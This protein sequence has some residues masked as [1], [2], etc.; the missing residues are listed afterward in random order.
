MQ[1]EKQKISDKV[2]AVNLKIE[3]LA[4]PQ[5]ALL[6]AEQKIQQ[7]ADI[8]QL[9]NALVT[10]QDHLKSLKMSGA[11]VRRISDE[12]KQAVQ[13]LELQWHLSQAQYLARQLTP[14]Q[15]CAVCGSTAHPNIAK[16]EQRLVSLEQI[17]T[18]KEEAQRW[19]HKL[20]AER[21]LYSTSSSQCNVLKTRVDD[22]L[23]TFAGGNT[24]QK[25]H[26]RYW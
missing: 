2:A 17:E 14:N 23:A 21:D 16:S 13:Q 22:A 1:A 10:Q 24:A 9:K 18:A 7:L 19:D 4:D 26:Q 11:E 3:Q 20:V 6:E 12:K 5:I 25:T 8:A 15:P